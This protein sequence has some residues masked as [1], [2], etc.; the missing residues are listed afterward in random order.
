MAG[1]FMA[2]LLTHVPHSPQHGKVLFKW[3]QLS[4]QFIPSN[5]REQNRP[6]FQHSNQCEGQLKELSPFHLT[7]ISGGK[8]QQA[9]LRKGTGKIRPTDTWGKI[10][11]QRP[12]R[13]QLRNSEKVKR[14]LSGKLNIQKKPCNTGESKNHTGPGKM[15]SQKSFQKTLT[16][17]C[18]Q[19]SHHTKVIS[20][21]LSQHR[22]S[23]PRLRE[24]AVYFLMPNFQ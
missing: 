12:T 16:S 20:E 23:P 6:C 17:G 11:H 9:L 22:V 10:L 5:M 19:G 21:E 3:R 24:A 13:D 7:Q 15:Y 2:F 1:N 14:R 18:L 8:K 4:S